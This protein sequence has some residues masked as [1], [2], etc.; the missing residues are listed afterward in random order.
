MERR[1][2]PQTKS[3][4]RLQVSSHHK[5]SRG[6]NYANRAEAQAQQPEHPSPGEQSNGRD[7]QRHLQEHFAKVKTVRALQLKFDVVLELT[8]LGFAFFLLV[9]VTLGLMHIV[10]ADLGQRVSVRCWNDRVRLANSLSSCPRM[11]LAW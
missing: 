7:H 9:F 8:G 11:F 2:R 5:S 3:L 6:Q 4:L 1:G 10:L